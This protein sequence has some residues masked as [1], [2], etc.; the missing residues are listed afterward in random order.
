MRVLVTGASGFVGGA[1]PTRLVNDR[2]FEAVGSVRRLI[3]GAITS[4]QCIEVAKP[5]PGMQCG[6]ALAGVDA[7]VHTA[8]R[9]HVMKDTAADPSAKYRYSNVQ[10]H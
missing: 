8:V 2:R 7:V 9:V 5:A 10:G 4:V 1:V 6:Y 3:P